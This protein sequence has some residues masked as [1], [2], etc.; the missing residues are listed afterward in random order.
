M[1][2]LRSMSVL[3]FSS[4]LACSGLQAPATV[5]PAPAGS[6]PAVEA[7]A[8]P[9]ALGAVATFTVEGAG[10]S[11]VSPTGVGSSYLSDGTERVLH[12]DG[13]DRHLTLISEGTKGKHRTERLSA[14]GYTVDMIWKV[15]AEGEGGVSYD[16]VL[17]V[18]QGERPAL[19]TTLSC[20]CGC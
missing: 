10:C 17:S 11:C 18:A 16:V 12:I 7:P 20:G 9:P 6:P 8:G 14:D 13:K 1:P 2:T 3:I 5:T 15:L 19:K 4:G